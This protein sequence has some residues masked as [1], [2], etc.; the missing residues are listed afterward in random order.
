M[1]NTCLNIVCNF[2]FSKKQYIKILIFIIMDSDFSSTKKTSPNTVAV[3]I[4]RI[5]IY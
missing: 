1:T 2:N 5:C 3:N 4:I